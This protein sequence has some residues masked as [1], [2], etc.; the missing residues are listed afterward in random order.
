MEKRI[1]IGSFVHIDG[2]DKKYAH[3][4][5]EF[6]GLFRGRWIP[7]KNFHITYRFIGNVNSRQLEDLKMIFQPEL[8]V[9]FEANLI[10]K[11][12]GVFPHIR[13][14]RVFFIKVEDKLKVLNQINDVVNN[15]LAILGYPPEHKPFK[16]HITLK[17][18]KGISAKD[19]PEKIRDFSDYQFGRQTKVRLSIIESFLTPKG[20]EYKK[21]E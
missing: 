20:A 18:I 1:F 6:G 12:V 9:E 16:P 2:F 4:K 21:V 11:G 5:K 7:E 14:P 17:R 10:Y 19:F 3:L 15:K 13:N 8:K